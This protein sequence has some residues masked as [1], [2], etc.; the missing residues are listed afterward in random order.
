[1]NP[2]GLLP[3][4]PSLLEELQTSER[5]HLQSHTN[6]WTASEEQHLGLTSV[7]HTHVEYMY[8]H[9]Q[10]LRHTQEL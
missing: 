3:G 1:M 10:T 7:L 2:Y 9:S 6:K 4:K 5:L 8:K